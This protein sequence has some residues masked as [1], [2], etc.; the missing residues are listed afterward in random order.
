[1]LVRSG[2]RDCDALL[3]LVGLANSNGPDF[4]LDWSSSVSRR[5]RNVSASLTHTRTK[6]REGKR[7][8]TALNWLQ[9]KRELHN[10]ENKKTKGNYYSY[11]FYFN[12]VLG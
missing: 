2:M 6:E 5:K 7:I 12:I 11:I 4:L 10:F 9:I 8:S 3:W 1:M